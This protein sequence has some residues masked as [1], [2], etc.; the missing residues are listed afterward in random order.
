MQP[1]KRQPKI[2]RNQL[3]A[4]LELINDYTD[5]LDALHTLLNRV[6]VNDES[7]IRIINHTIS[8][9]SRMNRAVDAVI[10]FEEAMQ[11]QLANSATHQAAIYAI[12]KSATPN[13]D[14]ALELFNNA[15]LLGFTDT[16]SCHHV[17]DALVDAGR[18]DDAISFYLENGLSIMVRREGH[19]TTVDLHGQ[20]SGST[21]VALS[22]YLTSL[23]QSSSLI[24]IYGRGSHS[25]PDALVDGLSPVQR[26]TIKLLEDMKIT[27]QQ[28]NRNP[29]R[30]KTGIYHPKFKSAWSNPL[31]SASASNSPINSKPS[32]AA[33]APANDAALTNENDHHIIKPN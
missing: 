16:V 9:L 21:Y 29:G 19:D 2:M 5:K 4:E 33:K 22:H 27:Y 18:I 12:T 32:D 3:Q 7:Y 17:I 26:A 11:R 15:K 25:R 14:K 23:S 28:D 30:L 24:I 31:T 13:A 10:L 6:P 1:R 20:S 8:S